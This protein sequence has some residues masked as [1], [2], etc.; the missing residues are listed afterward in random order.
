[1]T[2]AVTLSSSGSA[3]SA[4][5]QGTNYAE[6]FTLLGYYQVLIVVS[7]QR[8]GTTYRSHLH[9][10]RRPRKMPGTIGRAFIWGMA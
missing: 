1:L 9:E 2:E 5:C 8:F 4:V 3:V 6:I 10:S 7:Y